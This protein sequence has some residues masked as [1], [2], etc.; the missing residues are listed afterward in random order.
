[1][2]VVWTDQSRCDLRAIYN[3]TARD[4]ELYAGRQVQRLI[5]RIERTSTMPTRGHPVHEYP[6]PSM[7]EVHEGEYR[8]IFRFS[9]DE[10]QIV[11]L[12]HMKQDLPRRQLS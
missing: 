8:I 1:M 7:R 4:S 6:E 2:T 9:E 12:I 11:T 3:F 5:T 10:M